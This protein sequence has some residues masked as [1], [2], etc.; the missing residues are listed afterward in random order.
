MEQVFAYFPLLFVAFGAVI[1][2]GSVRG[3]VN[4]RRFV[5][6]ARRVPGVVA[7]VR[8][9]FAGRGEHLRASRRP[10]LTFTTVEGREVTTESWAVSDLGVGREVEVL[11]DPQDPT[12]AAPA[13]AVGG[14]YGGI[15]LG[16]VA[17]VAGLAFFAVF[18]EFFGSFGGGGF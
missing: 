4:G 14:G 3:I 12:H 17:A 10:V 6:G 18:S 16:L 15:V 1:A 8:T 13:G 7:D 5:R 2:W 11:Y 9:T